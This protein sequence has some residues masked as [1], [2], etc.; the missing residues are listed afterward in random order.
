MRTEKSKI[1]TKSIVWKWVKRTLITVGVV[2]AVLGLLIYQPWVFLP[3]KKVEISLPFAPEFD[4]AANLIPMGEIEQ[5]HNASTG[6]PDGHPGID[7]QWQEPTPVIA[8]GDGYI[9]RISKSSG[10]YSVEQSLSAYY[11][12]AY[13]EL[14]KIDSNIRLF[15]KVKKGQIIGYTRNNFQTHWDFASSSFLV[16]RLCPMGY[17]DAD[18]KKRIET[19]WAN[20][21]AKGNYKP[22]YPDI[23]NG[24]YKGKEK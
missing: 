8:V 13:Q 17:F 20:V 5:W 11:R 19:I 2:F 3:H 23:C 14:D 12:T 21:K 9:F 7:F 18:S 22:E 15:S 16:N 24:A 10:E 6:L 4:S 1:K